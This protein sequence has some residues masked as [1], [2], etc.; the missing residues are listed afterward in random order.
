[1]RRGCILA[2]VV[3]ARVVMAEPGA[4]LAPAD[5]LRSFKVAEDLELELV[6]HEPEI[7]QPVFLSFDERGRMWVVEFRQYPKP[8][9][10]TTVSHDQFWR[11]V[12]DK[13]PPR[14][15]RWPLSPMKTRTPASGANASKYSARCP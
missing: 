11:A 8:A 15:A 3:L 2:A 7:P 4:P 9:G 14:S 5:A 13:V 10:L 6:L 12:Y 1:M